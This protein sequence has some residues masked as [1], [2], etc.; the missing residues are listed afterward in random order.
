MPVTIPSTVFT[1]LKDLKEN[2]HRDWMQEH[3]KEYQNNEKELK[4]FYAEVEKGLNQKDQILIIFPLKK[5][6]SITTKN[7]YLS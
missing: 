7:Q 4:S 1:F 3:K 2:N 5:I 6:A